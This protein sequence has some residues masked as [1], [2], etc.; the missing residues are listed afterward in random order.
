MTLVDSG[1]ATLEAYLEA[2]QARGAFADYF[3]NDVTIDVVG[4]GQTAQGRAAVESM[5]RY[6]HEQAF[7]A[8]A[9]VKSLVVERNSAG[10]E[11]DFVG[12]HIGEFA[13]VAPTGRDIRVPYSVHYDLGGGR[14]KALRIYG[15]AGDL[16]RELSA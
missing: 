6:V 3:T 4:S 12:R 1:R 8:R 15:L 14:I 13:G 7:D 16:V 10:L 11:A 9:E 5:I 2:L